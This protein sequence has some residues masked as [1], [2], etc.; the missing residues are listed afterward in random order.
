MSWRA[1]LDSSPRR[2]HACRRRW[3]P[4]LLLQLRAAGEEEKLSDV[5]PSLGVGF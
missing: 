3:P 4:L 2:A 1:D 5:L